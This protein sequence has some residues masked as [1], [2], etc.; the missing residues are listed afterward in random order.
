MFLFEYY[1][2]GAALPVAVLCGEGDSGRAKA[3]H[4][5]GVA[6]RDVRRKGWGVADAG[7]VNPGERSRIIWAAPD[8][9]QTLSLVIR[10]VSMAAEHEAPLFFSV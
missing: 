6:S 1:A 3:A 4:L 10:E 8:G 2:S 9:S 7:P 5:E